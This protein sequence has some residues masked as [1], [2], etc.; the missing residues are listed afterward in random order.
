MK[1]IE[2]LSD[3]TKVFIIRIWLES[4]KV[5][6]RPVVWRGVIEEIRDSETD[7]E[8]EEGTPPHRVAF[9]HLKTLEDYLV[10]QL[11]KLGIPKDGTQ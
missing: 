9:Q 6:S 8:Q 3:K 11:K 5:N 7:E 1:K 2:F 4:R 10:L